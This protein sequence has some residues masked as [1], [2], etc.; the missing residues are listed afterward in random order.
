MGR[1]EDAVSSL[2][3]SL[4]IQDNPVT[5]NSLGTALCRMD[6]CAEGIVHFER[7][8][9]AAPSY[10]DALENLALAYA[11]V[12]R[13]QDAEKAQKRAEALRGHPIAPGK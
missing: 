2:K 1:L 3:E 8:V 6:Q 11:V 10:V 4:E 5:R 12:G 9:A 7:A 13:Q